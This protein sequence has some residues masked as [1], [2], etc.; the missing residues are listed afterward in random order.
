MNDEIKIVELIVSEVTEPKNDGTTGSALYSVPFRLNRQP[1]SLWTEAFVH[2]W[3]HPPCF[4]S[5]H[6]PGIADVYGDKIVLNG[7]TL[8]E[9]KRDHKQTLE[10]CVTEANN[11]ERKE[12]AKQQKQKVIEE[13]KSEEFRKSVEEQSKNIKFD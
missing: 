4:N 5:K 2:T 3:N 13:K 8:E 6:R 11:I 12:I 9:V 10:L 7:T 1:S